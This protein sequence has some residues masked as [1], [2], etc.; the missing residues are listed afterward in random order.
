MYIYFSYF[1]RALFRLFSSMLLLVSLLCFSCLVFF[2]F[3]IL[4]YVSCY[5]IFLF[6]FLTFPFFIVFPIPPCSYI[7]YVFVIIFCFLYFM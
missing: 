3:I 6:I 5:V 4:F 2:D 7:L 1:I